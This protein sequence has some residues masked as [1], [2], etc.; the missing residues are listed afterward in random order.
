MA[1]RRRPVKPVKSHISLTS[2][3]SFRMQRDGLTKADLRAA[4]QLRR[5]VKGALKLTSFRSR[6]KAIKQS[7]TGRA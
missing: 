5:P 4:P 1:T 7:F 3:A 6:L 2:V